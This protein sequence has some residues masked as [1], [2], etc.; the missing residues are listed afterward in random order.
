MKAV[1]LVGG[2]GTRLRP[3]TINTPK[4]M[5]PVLNTPFLE[6]VIHHLSRHNASEITLALSHLAQPIKDYFG[7]GSRFGV[8]LNYVLEKAP[9]GTAGAVK[10]TERSESFLD[11]TFLVLNGDIITDLDITAMMD[12]HRQKGAK[13]TIALTPVDDPTSYGLIETNAYGRVTRFLEKPSWSQVTT[14]M[15]NAGTYILEPDVMAYIPPQTRFSFEHELF[16]LFLRKDKPIYAYPSAAY[17]IDIGTPEKYLRLNIDLLSGKSSQ[18]DPGSG[19]KVVI[20]EKCRIHPTAEIT[21][22]AVIGSN[23]TIGQRV[24]LRGP[25]VIGSGCVILDDAVITESV[26][27]QDVNIGSR[28]RLKGSVI[29]SNCRLDDGST[30]EEAV[31]GDNVTVAS[32][33]KLEPG[34][35]IWPGTAVG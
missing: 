9:L 26:I 27:W 31:L 21:A 16:P 30:V 29:A 19:G 11:E 12:F 18:Y 5:V 22:P 2:Q 3:L 35:K 8:R 15:I 4:A 17:W 32:G 24:R 13:I 14:N 20:G 34:S 25:V 1:I 23:C 33:Y 6:H 10:N 28:V 7:D